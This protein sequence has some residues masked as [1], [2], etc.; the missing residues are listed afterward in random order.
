MP[1]FGERMVLTIERR[2]LMYLCHRCPRESPFQ[3]LV[4]VRVKV[5]GGMQSSASWLRSKSLVFPAEM[6][7]AVA[8]RTSGAPSDCTIPTVIGRNAVS[9]LT[10]RFV[11]G[12]HELSGTQITN[13]KSAAPKRSHSPASKECS[14]RS[15][16]R[17]KVERRG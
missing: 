17:E 11:Q 6:E 5:V 15:K 8:I 7:A 4:Q 13:S 14:K 3:L 16:D 9:Q 10:T 2:W 12:H 1:Q